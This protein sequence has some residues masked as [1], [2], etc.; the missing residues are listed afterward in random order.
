MKAWLNEQDVG[1]RGDALL[2]LIYAEQRDWQWTMCVNAQAHGCAERYCN[3]ECRAEAARAYHAVLCVAHCGEQLDAASRLFEQRVA[4]R[5]QA[6]TALH[7]L[8]VAHRRTNLLLI[9]RMLA[10]EIIA[11][12]ANGGDLNGAASAFDAFVGYDAAAPGDADA[13]RHLTT[14][15]LP[16]A[17]HADAAARLVTI[18][19]VRRL[20]AVLLLNASTVNPLS[21]AATALGALDAERRFA[22]LRQLDAQ[23]DERFKHADQFLECE[24]LRRLCVVGT[25]L[26]RVINVANHSCRPSAVVGCGNTHHQLSLVAARSIAAGDEITISYCDETQNRAT[27]RAF[28]KK[29]YRFDCRCE[30]CESND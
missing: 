6:L 7:A 20:N 28:L 19:R 17:R 16:H 22:L 25:G 15:L 9:A 21:V 10:R 3:A 13:V 30:R 8:V 24:P 2:T 11:L 23:L 26:Y 4:Q 27:R 1:E 18:E 14:L 12:N 29:H 5:R